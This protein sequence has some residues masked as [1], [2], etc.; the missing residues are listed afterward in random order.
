VASL[1]LASPGAATC[2]PI[3]PQQNGRSFFVFFSHLK[4]DDLFIYRLVTTPTIF[5][6]CFNKF[7][8]KK[9]ILIRL[10]PLDGV[11]GGGPPSP[12]PN[13]ATAFGQAT[14]QN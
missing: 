5:V 13:D 10:S 14:V 1:R 4:S 7:S 6:Q 9:I 11:T 8:R 3:F 12:A 2:H